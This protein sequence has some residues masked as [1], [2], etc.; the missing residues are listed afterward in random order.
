MIVAKEAANKSGV[1]GV[2]SRDTGSELSLRQD[3][4]VARQIMSVEG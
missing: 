2:S 3:G 4:S 1:Y